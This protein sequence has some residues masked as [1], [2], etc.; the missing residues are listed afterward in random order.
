MYRGHRPREPGAWSLV[1]N[2]KAIL[3]CHTIKEK[4]AKCDKLAWNFLTVFN[5][6]KKT[7]WFDS[8]NFTVAE[9]ID[10]RRVE[11][12]NT[13][14]FL[15]FCNHAT[16][17]VG[18]VCKDWYSTIYIDILSPKMYIHFDQWVCFQKRMRQ[19]H[20]N[21]LILT[22]LVSSRDIGKKKNIVRLNPALVTYTLL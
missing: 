12:E 7:I 9:Y 3:V 20:P 21:L 5:N 1:K 4:F 19:S 14:V 11:R 2:L 13:Q 15:E 18:S 16:S 10:L 8:Y 17:R 22:A 6:H